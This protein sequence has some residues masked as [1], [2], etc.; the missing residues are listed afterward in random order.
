[1]T[2]RNAKKRLSGIVRHAM[3]NVGK[4]SD[5]AA[6]VV[7]SSQVLAAEDE[8]LSEL[9]RFHSSSFK[10]GKDHGEISLSHRVSSILFENS[11]KESGAEVPS[12]PNGIPLNISIRMKQASRD[13]KQKYAFKNF[14]SHRFKKIV[15]GC[16]QRLGNQ[17]MFD[18]FDNL[19]RSNGPNQYNAMIEHYIE[20]AR[21]SSDLEYALD[22]LGKAFELFKAMRERG[23][24][25]EEGTY[26]PLLSYLIDMGMVEEFEIFKDIIL[27]ANPKSSARLGYY[28]MLFCILANDEERIEEFCS[29]ISDSGESLSSLQENYLIALCEKDRKENLQKLLDVVD[30]KDVSSVEVLTS[31]FSYLGRSLLESVA[32][33]FLQ[34]LK[35]SDKGMQNVSEL[36]FSF[37]ANTTNSTVG[38]V[39]LAFN[40]LHEDLNVMPSSDAYEKLIKYSC[41]WHEVDTALDIVEQML[42][43][44]DMVSSGS[45]QSLLHTI[46]QIN[47]FHL[48]RRIYSIMCH[49]NVKPTG[50]TTRCMISLCVKLKD[51]EGAYNMLDVL[52][53][54]N[55]PPNSSMYNLILAG[56]F[57]EKNMKGAATV[58]K[59]M[60]DADVKP[61]S[62]TF[63]YLINNCDREEDIVKYWEEMKEKGVQ[64][65][66]QVFMSLINAYATLGQFEKAK[67]VVLY[68]EVPAKQLNEVKS[69]LISALASNG[70]ITEALSL[71]EEMKEADCPVEAKAII[72]LIEHFNPKGEFSTLV[73][74]V[75]ELDDK[76]CWI[77]G[78][79]RVIL[80]AIRNDYTSFV[81]D[82]L[83]ETKYSLSNDDIDVEYLF[84]EVFCSI[85]EMEYS[86]VNLGIAL[87]KYM[88]EE[89][90]LSPTRRCLDFLL[91]ACVNA[92]DKESALLVW[93]EYQREGL[94]YNVLT[95]LRMYQA[96]LAARDHKGAEAIA[97]KIAKDDRD[98]CCIIEK[99][100]EAFSQKPRKKGRK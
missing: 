19:G 87:I 39:I 97:S 9:M 81:I 60:V 32:K 14:Q 11:V 25:I 29:T 10:T 69:V 17:A 92:K 93:K 58:I 50:E 68:E 4:S 40:K 89:L 76:K 49:E 51:F 94:P 38:D 73:G 36:I 84:E 63:S 66:K 5:A 23:F 62:V 52:K 90:G 83:K 75:D 22:Q 35:K 53:K 8:P 28:E 72:S 96:L 45:L 85:A 67:Q 18:I 64:A 61:D 88:R 98:V 80:Y 91:S 20:N 74:L 46:E 37:A 77:D 99:S 16:A 79:F 86:D 33:K 65:T 56:Y 100:R 21:E 12:L 95:Y 34:E 2:V 3:R 43:A 1:M 6:A 26:G 59:H 27:E 57:R 54:S 15:R 31:I 70:E 24:P 71:Y 44:G 13:K 42:E 48:V 82:L 47:E 78:F 41:D 30:I 55:L 7:G